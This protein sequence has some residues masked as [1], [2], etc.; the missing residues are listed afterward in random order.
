MDRTWPTQGDV[1]NRLR[2]PLGSLSATEL[3]ELG[4]ALDAATA[5]A[6]KLPEWREAT[7]IPPDAWNAVVGLA[8]IDFRQANA[9]SGVDTFTGDQ[10]SAEGARGRYMRQL[11]YWRGGRARVG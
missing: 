7:E 8:A 10:G 1:A 9:A 11:G 2:I 3:V 6:R 4:N 5:T